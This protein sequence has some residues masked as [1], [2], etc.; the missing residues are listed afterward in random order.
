[1]EKKWRRGRSQKGQTTRLISLLTPPSLSLISRGAA[2]A[3]ARAEQRLGA[4]WWLGVVGAGSTAILARR[5]RDLGRSCAR[6]Q[7]ATPGQEIDASFV[8][9]S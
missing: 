5:R 4:A 7:R 1:M 3:W 9:I 8:A 6:R 2:A